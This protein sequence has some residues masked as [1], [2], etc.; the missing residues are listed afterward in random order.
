MKSIIIYLIVF[1]AITGRLI[2][3]PN[4]AV[5]KEKM[6]IFSAWA[7][8]WQGEGSMQMGP[9]EPKKSTVDEKVELKLDGTILVMEGIGKAVNPETKQEMV[10]HHAY[11]VV[12][13]DQVANEYKFKTYLKDGRSSDAWFKTTGDNSFQW[14]LKVPQGQIR[15]TIT[16]DPAKKTWNEIGEFSGD[17]NSWNK[18][19][20][21]KLNKKD[22]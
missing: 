5:A 15:Y 8:H 12:S 21:M 22:S 7:G 2:A 11:G 1:A 16:L 6:K 20:E 4:E 10:V 19:F 17:G 14:G 3:Q 18:F 13:Y 9:G